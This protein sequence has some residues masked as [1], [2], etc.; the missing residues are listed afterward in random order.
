M[1]KKYH[2]RP[3]RPSGFKEFEATR[4]Y[5]QSGQACGKVLRPMHRPP[6]PL[7]EI[8]LVSISVRS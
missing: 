6:L 3:G 7:Q 8:T 5:G 1:V 2:Y 4:I